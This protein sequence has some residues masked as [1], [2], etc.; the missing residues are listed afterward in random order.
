MNS[1]T[2]DTILFSCNVKDYFPKELQTKQP[3]QWY[4]E[5]EDKQ[6]KRKKQVKHSWIVKA[7]VDT[8]ENEVV[9]SDE[10]SDSALILNEIVSSFCEVSEQCILLQLDQ[11][12]DFLV[13]KDWQV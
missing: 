4:Q 5:K 12:T 8:D 11:C 13:M 1:L 2:T 10:Y 3:K 9:H 7:T 6:K